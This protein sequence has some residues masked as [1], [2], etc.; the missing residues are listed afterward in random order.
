MPETRSTCP[1]CGVGCGVVIEHD[2]GRITGVRGDPQH[3]ANFGRLCSKGSTLHLTATEHVLRDQRARHPMGRDSRDAP[4][5]RVDWDTALDRI[6]GAL[7]T[8]IRTRGPDSI[9]IYLSGQ[10]TTED[11]AV[12]NKL[13]RG[14]IGTNN[15]DTNSRLCMSSA[16]AGYKQSLGADAPPAC[17]DDVA[18]AGCLFIAGSNTAFAH[19][20]LYRRIEDARAA[21]PALKTIVVDPRRSETADDADLHLPLQPGTDVALFHAM[22]HVMVWEGWLDIGFIERHTSGFAELKSLVAAWT[23]REAARVCGLKAE[24][25]ETAARWFAWGG[26]VQPSE[27]ARRRPTLSLYCQGL[28]QSTSGTAKNSAL[29]NLHLATGQIGRAGAGPFSLTGQP[30]AMGG[31]EAGGMATVLPGHRDPANAAH[32]DEIARLWGVPALSAKPGHTAVAMFE[33]AARGELEVLWIVCTNPAMSMPDQHMVRQ[34]LERTPLVIV[35]E[36]FAATETTAFADLVLPAATW[37]EKDGTVTNSERC[38]SRVRTAVPP[39]GEARADWAIAADVGRRLEALRHPGRPSAFGYRDAESVWR[40][41]RETTRGRD[42]DITGLS[43]PLLDDLGPQRWP[44]PEGAAR[45]RDRLYED[46]RFATD[47]GRARFIAC[48]YKPVAEG[49]DA[50][51]PFALTTGRLRDQWHGMSRSGTV[52]QLFG[53]APQPAVHLSP[54]D[55]TRRRLNDGDLVEVRSRRG[56]LVLP[57]HGDSRVAPLQA[58]LPMHWGARFLG[59]RD[60]Q[61]RSRR[62]TNTLT[63]GRSCPQSRQ[64]ELKHSAVQV[65]PADLPWRLEAAAWLPA[66]NWEAAREALSS[67]LDAFAYASIVP[68]G[69]PGAVRAGPSGRQTAAPPGPLAGRVGLRWSAAA[70]DAPPEPVLEALRRA[71]GLHGA[72]LLRYADA[73]TGTARCLRLAGRGPDAQIESLMLAGPADSA[74]WLLPWWAAAE[75]IGEHARA[76]LL[77]HPQAPADAS[78]RRARR[79]VCNCLG[80]DEA[81]ISAALAQVEGTPAERLAA[82]QAKLRC[83][84]QCGSCQPELRRL[85][86]RVVPRAAAALERA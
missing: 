6:V 22:L 9:G 10:L 38:I 41:H 46:G 34:A 31:R 80:V 33:A 71:L 82:L 44:M 35:Q 24:Q 58:W 18:H 4:R 53:H 76:L 40:E 45:G 81:A 68:V 60:G 16:V 47:D 19:P 73:S 12:F 49:T 64:P 52:A 1:Y 26:D 3:P 79:E 84:T 57:V 50:R 77:P 14:L 37:G 30:N 63:H 42:L 13:A 25:I 54:Q 48:A 65:A 27:G 72:M 11:Y 74:A 2:A 67:M 59:G 5:R 23:P 83:G 32:R 20:V 61:G 66:E 55:L 29:I 7:D 51:H 70:T 17:Y 75:P 85:V 8:A 56:S 69:W 86:A 28:N 78:V 15:V 62:G 39:P 43:W 36:A 21:N